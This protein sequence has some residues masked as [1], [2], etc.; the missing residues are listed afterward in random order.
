MV[1]IKNAYVDNV[2]MALII[3]ISKAIIII[4]LDWRYITF[5]K[6]MKTYNKYKLKLRN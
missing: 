6:S 2:V 4:K 3:V 5:K 1:Y